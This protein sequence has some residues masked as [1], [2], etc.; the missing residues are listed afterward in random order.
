MFRERD[1][2]DIPVFGLYGGALETAPEVLHCE[3]IAEKSAPLRG[4]IVQHRHVYS[5]QIVEVWNGEVSAEIDGA[6]FRPPAPCVFAVPPTV[7]HGFGFSPNTDGWVM[8]MPD[9]LRSHAIARMAPVGAVLERPIVADLKTPTID[10]I[11]ENIAGLTYEYTHPTTGSYLSIRARLNL[12]LVGLVRSQSAALETTT[13]SSRAEGCLQR[14][15]WLVDEH[16]RQHW[17]VQRYAREIGMTT[18]HLNRLCRTVFG[19]AP[20]TIIRRRLLLEARRLLAY[21]DNGVAEIAYALG[22]EDPA[23]FTRFFGR[24]GGASPATYRKARRGE[25]LDPTV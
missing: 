24:E 4:H 22:F 5:F 13:A 19:V 14:F 16:Y 11:L 15:R 18:A 25:D 7:V 10:L 3:T 8:T 9:V 6:I 20:A 17:T 21:T 12:I 2:S 1:A 23:Y